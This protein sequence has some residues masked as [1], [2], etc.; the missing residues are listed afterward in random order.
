MKNKKLSNT[1]IRLALEYFR[2]MKK[3]CIKI[4]SNNNEIK[5]YDIAINA[6]ENE[7][8]RTTENDVLIIDDSSLVI[9]L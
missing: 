1:D 2:G 6:L 4:D 8:T 7:L 5:N 9:N 3:V